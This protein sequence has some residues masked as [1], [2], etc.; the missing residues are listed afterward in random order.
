MDDPKLIILF[1]GKRKSGKDY[2]CEKLE[3]EYVLCKSPSFS[4]KINLIFK[5]G[6]VR[7]NVQLSEY[8]SLSKGSMLRTTV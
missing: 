7:T 5:L 1:S 8:L 3:A 6:W 2:I 4:N